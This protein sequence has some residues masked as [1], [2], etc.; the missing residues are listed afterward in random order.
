M[1]E[2]TSTKRTLARLLP[3]IPSPTAIPPIGNWH[4]RGAC[5]G[6]EPEAFFPAN[7]DSGAQ[8]RGICVTCPVRED[9]LR[10][11][12]EA[13]EFGIWGGLDQ[14]QRRALRRRQRRQARHGR[15]SE[16]NRTRESA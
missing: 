8:A 13:D 12:T 5:A 11:A 3:V 6:E 10:Y 7:G 4:R 14:Q 2:A 9:C 16:G 1:P 15:A